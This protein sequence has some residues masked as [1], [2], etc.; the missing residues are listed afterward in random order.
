MNRYN[1]PG[2]ISPPLFYRVGE[3]GQVLV[4]E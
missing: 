1:H 4:M 2:L 3:E